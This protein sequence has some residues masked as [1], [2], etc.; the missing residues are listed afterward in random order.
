VIGQTRD[1]P[2]RETG[3]ETGAVLLALGG[4]AAAFGAASRWPHTDPG[5]HAIA[6]P[7]SASM[8]P[9]PTKQSTAAAISANR[10]GAAMTATPKS[11]APLMPRLPSSIGRA[12]HA[13]APLVISLTI[14]GTALAVAG[15]LYA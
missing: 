15:C 5:A 1:M 13:V 3:K 9:A 8:I 10:C 2:E 4:L 7:R 14:I 11:H 12:Q 6:R